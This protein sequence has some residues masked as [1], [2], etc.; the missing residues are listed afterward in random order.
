VVAGLSDEVSDGECPRRVYDRNIIRD[1]PTVSLQT[2]RGLKLTGS[3]N[4]RIMSDDG[5]WV[6]LDSLSVGGRVRIS[7][8]ADLWPQE[9]V[10]IRW[11]P[12][13]R[14]TQHDIAVRAGVSHSTVSRVLSGGG[15]RKNPERVAVAVALYRS[16]ENVAL[17]DLLPAKREQ[18]AVPEEVTPDLG[19]FL[20]YLVGDGHISRVKHH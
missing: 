11:Q 13:R 3:N 15:T 10:S 5:S 12:P 14:M 1:H 2:R 8:G 20:G 7:G 18:I 4:H 19:A 17:Q 9:R 6:R 16:A